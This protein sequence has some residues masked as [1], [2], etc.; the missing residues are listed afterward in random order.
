MRSVSPVAKVVGRGSNKCA[1]RSSVVTTRHRLMVVVSAVGSRNC[2]ACIS[3][4]V[5]RSHIVPTRSKCVGVSCSNGSGAGH[6]GV[7]HCIFL[8]FATAKESSAAS[9]GVAVGRTGAET[10]FL[11]VVAS[12]SQLDES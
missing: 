5:G 2:R 6:F 3:G 10:L 1:G 12:E 9:T 7:M 8:R 11:L 4:V